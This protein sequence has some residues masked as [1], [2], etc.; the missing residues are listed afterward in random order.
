MTRALYVGLDVSLEMTSSCVVDAEGGMILETKAVSDPADI[1]EVLAGIDG[2]FE[3]VGFEAGPLSLWLYN[4]L[5]RA[6]LLPV[7]IEAR[8]AKVAMM[9]MKRNKNERNEARSLA[10]LIRSGWFKA[11]HVKS[12]ESQEMRTL[13]MSRE[14]F[15]NKLRDHENE[16]RGRLR[17]FGLKVGRIAA[18]DFEA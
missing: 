1:G 2:T 13:L 3:R 18:R 6:G 5:T 9:A 17:P 14:L 12:T 7:R 16:L 4:G 15:A 11:V 10:Q 8:H